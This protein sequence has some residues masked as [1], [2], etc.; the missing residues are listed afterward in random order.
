MPVIH[1]KVSTVGPAGPPGPAGV[2]NP[3]GAWSN[4]NNYAQGDMV[5]YSS[6][7]YL[8]LQASTSASPKQPDTYPAYWQAM[9]GAPGVPGATGAG[10]GGTSTTSMTPTSGNRSFTTQA[11]MAWSVGAPIQATSASTPGSYMAGTVY[12]Y[13]STTLVI[14]VTSYAG[15][16]ESDWVFSAPTG[17]QGPQGIQGIQG[18]QGA[19]GSCYM[20][21]LIAGPDTTKTITGAT[22]GLGN[23]A[24]MVQVYDNSSPR[25]AIS[26]GW[27]VNATTFDVLIS[28]AV[29]QSN[30]YVIVVGGTPEAGGLPVGTGIVKV[31]GGTPSIAVVNVDYMPPLAG[32]GLLKVTAGTLGMATATVDYQPPLGYTA[33]N[34]ASKG[35][36][37]GYAPLD[38]G[39]RVPF[40]YLPTNLGAVTQVYPNY[41]WNQTPGGTLAATS[42]QTTT[43][44]PVPQGVN[45][46]DTNH[47][48]YIND[49]STPANS[50]VVTITG[51]S[52]VSG[53]SS[54]TVIFT[55]AHTHTGS[56]TIGTATAGI[57][58]AIN[59][60]PLYG[61]ANLY[62]PTG[63]DF[64][65]NRIPVY[66]IVYVD[67]AISIVGDGPLGTLLQA[68]YANQIVFDVTVSGCRFRDF[69]MVALVQQTSGGAA[70]RLGQPGQIFSPLF[71]NLQIG[72]DAGIAGLNG[73]YIPI[74]SA[75]C[76]AHVIRFCRF[77]N[78]S[79]DAI[80]AA[81]AAGPDNNGP[82]IT[83]C[84]FYISSAGVH[85]HS[86]FNIANTS[87][88]V[89]AHNTVGTDNDNLLDYGV[90]WAST[91]GGTGINISDNEIETTHL[92]GIYCNNSSAATNLL[93]AHGN[94]I[95]NPGYITGSWR[96]IYVRGN[97]TQV[98]VSGNIVQGAGAGT[99]NT[100]IEIAD[101][102]SV[103][104]VS[105]NTIN[106]CGTG[107]NNSGSGSV[108]KGANGIFNTTTPTAGSFATAY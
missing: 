1:A 101:T 35:A 104:T 59:T 30:Y 38:S 10:Y 8:A 17:Q 11:G 86:A 84:E 60:S 16:A 49:I 13:S 42:G 78:W 40:L 9:G 108:A 28:F 52:A 58:E 68:Q 48:L 26:V 12:S 69:G 85:A 55:C 79:Y 20:S 41:Y 83:D 53:A 71:D 94:M 37:N 34:V 45:G 88:I 33:E 51:G 57:Q 77:F 99:S 105:G 81:D 72:N 31:A 4:G 80:V 70:F 5:T 29:A 95:A 73:F 98:G 90:Y 39:S 18:I 50:E 43:L 2:T 15:A 75:N 103:V 102:A 6:A 89:F 47:Q 22:H 65:Y 46:S 87:A 44:S 107:I 62:M 76:S 91:A 25:N 23:A 56:W 24:L 82:T 93:N 97:V 67:R 21:A 3:R 100:A 36:A 96:G 106:Q 54:G 61:C 66:G 64:I 19:Q 32:T 27:S 92:A 63:L 7:A 14:A 74:L